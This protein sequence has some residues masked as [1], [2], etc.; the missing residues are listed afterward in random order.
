MNK[1]EIDSADL[2]MDVE[3]EQTVRQI[4]PYA[5]SGTVVKFPMRRTRQVMV[6]L[7]QS[8]GHPVPEGALVR[9]DGGSEFIVGRRGE[10]WLTD[11]PQ[12]DRQSLSVSWSNGAC[13]LMLELPAAQD[14]MPA[15]LGPLICEKVAP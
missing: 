2:P 5:R 6:V 10:A 7:R 12:P 13:R 3:M 9:L 14:A 4:V 1:L 11:L 15:K 8:G